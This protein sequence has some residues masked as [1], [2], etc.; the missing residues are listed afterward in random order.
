MGNI[1]ID[2][3]MPY[4]DHVEARDF[5]GRFEHDQPLVF[6]QQARWDERDKIVR[7]QN[8]GYEQEA[9]HRVANLAPQLEAREC[10]IRRAPE[11][12]TRRRHENVIVTAEA[13]N[14]HGPTMRER[15]LRADGYD[16]VLAV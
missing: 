5:N 3:R 11:G 15:V 12:S 10:L 16:V 4:G 14:G 2:P 9:R 13:L 7:L 6:T 1:L 8:L